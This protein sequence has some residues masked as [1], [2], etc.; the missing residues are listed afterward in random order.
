MP[1][2]RFEST[3]RREPPRHCIELGHGA[4]GIPQVLYA[5]GAPTLLCGVQQIN[6]RIPDQVPQPLNA[7]PV[8]LGVLL[9]SPTQLSNAKTT[10]GTTI[11]VK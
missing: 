4:G 2:R 1:H 11:A 7:V 6:L 8:M 9:Q 3:W 10:H 5:G